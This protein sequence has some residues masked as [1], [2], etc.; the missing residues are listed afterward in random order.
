MVG[1]Y[2]SHPGWGC[3]LSSTDINTQSSFEALNSRA[4]VPSKFL[5]LLGVFFFGN[6]ST[7]FGNS[8]NRR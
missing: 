5:D 1:W 7:S 3:W 2:H 6:S 4:H 8:T